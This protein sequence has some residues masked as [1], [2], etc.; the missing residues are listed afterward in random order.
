MA[1][2]CSNPSRV[3]LSCALQLGDE[4]LLESEVE[5]LDRPGV[6]E[7]DLELVETRHAAPRHDSERDDSHEG[8]PDD[9]DQDQPHRRGLAAGHLPT[10]RSRLLS[11]M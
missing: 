4:K 3:E 9:R 6:L 5:A 11:A 10:G 8:D 7:V 2:E 1:A